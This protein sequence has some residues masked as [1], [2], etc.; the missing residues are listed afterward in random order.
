M[1]REREEKKE[2][3]EKEKEI[4][5]TVVPFVW[6][7]AK[8]EGVH[9]AKRALESR[10]AEIEQICD[11]IVKAIEQNYQ[12]AENLHMSPLTNVVGRSNTSLAA[13]AR[14]IIARCEGLVGFLKYIKGFFKFGGPIL[15]LIDLVETIKEL[16]TAL[17]DHDLHDGGRTVAHHITKILILSFVSITAVIGLIFAAVGLTFELA[18]FG[19][20]V[21]ICALP[22][23]FLVPPKG[24][25]GTASDAALKDARERGHAY[26]KQ[27][28]DTIHKYLHDPS[29]INLVNLNALR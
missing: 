18:T 17:E 26:S 25:K 20:L 24:Y 3:W 2:F 21:G 6:D 4:S 15:V 10:V 22:L 14:R 9:L 16:V 8:D 11:D 13:L 29:P 12:T 1:D 19:S 7:L 28:M 5:L 23:V 27:Y